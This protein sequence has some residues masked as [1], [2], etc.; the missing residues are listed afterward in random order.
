MKRDVVI[1][2]S[3]QAGARVALDL[4]D[5][6]FAGTITLVGAEPHLPYERPQLS[7]EML[8]DSA[9][10]PQFIAEAQEWHTREIELLLGHSLVDAD[11]DS[12]Q[13]A[14]DDGRDLTYGHLVLATGT[15]AR[16][17]AELSGLAVPVH[18]MRT[19]DDAEAIRQ[20]LP[21]GG[22]IVIVG[23]GIIGLEV[24][25]AAIGTCD[26]TVLEAGTGL[27]Q[28]AVP[29]QMAAHLATLHGEKGVRFRYN[30]RP[31]SSS[32]H[33][34]HLSDGSSETADLV[35]VGIGVEPQPGIA[36]MFG[37]PE[38]RPGLRVESS[39]M[40]ERNGVLAIGDAAEQFS[41]CHDR[42]MRIETWANANDQAAAA[43]ATLTGAPQPTP[44]TP[45]FWS[46]QYDINFQ[47]TGDAIGDSTVLRGDPTSGRF[48]VIALRGD[49]IVGGASVGM[50]KD[51]AALRRI[52]G[53][54]VILPRTQIEDLSFNLRKAIPT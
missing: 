52:A 27:L 16:H 43:V 23:G 25:A 2:G 30:A 9:R 26:V 50:P 29:S 36:A 54:G 21:Q 15:A 33:E 17:C 39:A 19:I 18:V 44:P 14:I 37:L 28:R 38:D 22:K 40:T 51:I 12:R 41:V 4:R 20:R 24:A 5:A 45:W 47:V 1:V 31:I 11:P 35:V 8:A 32:G 53:R 46:D 49:E 6:G 34:I 42:W 7:K 10:P 13:L 48:S 3:G